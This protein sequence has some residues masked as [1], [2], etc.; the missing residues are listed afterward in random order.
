MLG[1][2]EASDWIHVMRQKQEMNSEHTELGLLV[3]L[4]HYTEGYCEFLHGLKKKSLL[5]GGGTLLYLSAWETEGS[6]R[7]ADL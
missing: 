2:L 4:G 3:T 6:Q 7:Q 5:G 1:L